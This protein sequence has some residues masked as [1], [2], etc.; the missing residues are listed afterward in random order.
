MQEQSGQGNDLEITPCVT[1][2]LCKDQIH[3]LLLEKHKPKT[4][5][6]RDLSFTCLPTKVE[7]ASLSKRENISQ[8]L[9]SNIRFRKRYLKYFLEAVFPGWSSYI[10]MKN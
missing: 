2:L 5:K 6:G 7:I 3:P 1:E 8:L 4:T 9:L 10:L